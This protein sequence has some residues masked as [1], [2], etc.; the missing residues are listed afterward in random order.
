MVGRRHRLVRT[1]KAAG[2]SQ[3]RLA[4]TIGVE[5]TTV[6]RWE[7]G[8]TCPQPWARPKLARA[9]GISDQS[10]AE[11]LG[12]SADPLRSPQASHSVRQ[13]NY[14]SITFVARQIT[15]EDL[16]ITRRDA[17]AA[18][19][20]VVLAGAALT[21][22]LQ[23]WLVPINHEE[24]F[25]KNKAGFSSSELVSLEGL[26]EQIRNCISNGNGTLARKA[27]VAQLNDVTDR[28]HEISPRRETWR[29]F[30]VAA[31]LSDV[32]AS[33]SWDA[34]LHRSAQQY[35]VLSVQLAKLAHDDRF[36]AVVLAALARQCYD[37]GRPR[38]GLEIV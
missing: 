8:E 5:R 15:G 2:F 20:S 11:L 3:E 6:M 14:H 29:A 37:L 17:L 10:L 16:S 24:E 34:G 28:L 23:Q 35:Y 19:A 31:E 18:G 25:A 26:V 9:L 38:D 1:R 21:E 36:A 33:M 22:P 32:V 4:E 27:A 12:E 7:R 13:W 30:K